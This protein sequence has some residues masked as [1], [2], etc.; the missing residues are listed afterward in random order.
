MVSPNVGLFKINISGHMPQI[1]RAGADIIRSKDESGHA[2]GEVK[3][4]KELH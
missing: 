1:S 3:P 2:N 4:L